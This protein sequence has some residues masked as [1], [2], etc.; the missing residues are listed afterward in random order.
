MT[1]DCMTSDELALWQAGRDAAPCVDCPA[2]FRESERRAGRCPQASPG[3]LAQ[4]RRASDRRRA[5]QRRRDCT[6][7][8]K[9]M[10]RAQVAEVRAA[11]TNE[12]YGVVEGAP[13]WDTAH[14]GMSV[15]LDLSDTVRDGRSPL[16]PES[17]RFVSGG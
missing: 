14:D 7:A 6:R 3:R 11:R 13:L 8:W 15:N 16:I 12:R 9:A 1:Y 2:S 17:G 5:R 10:L 4:M